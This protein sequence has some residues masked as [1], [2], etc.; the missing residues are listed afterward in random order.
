MRGYSGGTI[1]R[2][3]VVGGMVFG[4]PWTGVNTGPRLTPV[5]N[6]PKAMPP[7]TIRRDLVPPPQST[8]ARTV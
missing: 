1:S 3:T 8:H 4:S 5:H 6:D 7:T 2:L